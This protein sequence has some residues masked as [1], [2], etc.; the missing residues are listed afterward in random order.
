MHRSQPSP[1]A[2]RLTAW[3]VAATV[4]PLAGLAWLGRTIVEH[5]RDRG[6]IERREQAL[7]DSAAALKRTLAEAEERLEI[8][9]SADDISAAAAVFA[10]RSGAGLAVFGH[11]GLLGRGGAALPYYPAREDAGVGP[12][13]LF[14]AADREEV[15][16][17][18]AGAIAALQPLVQSNDSGVRAEALL[19]LARNY[20]KAGDTARTLAAY[21]ALGALENATAADRPA[22]LTAR[23]GRAI[24]LRDAARTADLRRE[25]TALIA[26]LDDGRW[27]L[28][29]AQYE[30]AREQAI[31]WTGGAGAAPIDADRLTLADA[32]EAAWHTWR[33]ATTAKAVERQRR[34]VRTRHG[35]A[36]VLTRTTA[37][38]LVMFVAGTRFLESAWLAE[39]RAASPDLDFALTEGDGTPVI[40]RADAPPQQQT[41]RTAYMTSLPWTVHAISTGSSPSRLSRT[42]QLSLGAVALTAIMLLA[43]AYVISRAIAR[44]VSVAALQSDFVAAV[45]HEFRTPLTTIRQLSELLTRGRVS[46]DD[47]RQQFYETLLRESDRLQRLVE[48]LLDFGRMEARAAEYRFDRVEP[49]PFVREVVTDFQQQI[50]AGFVVDLRVRGPLPPIRADRGSL[51]RVLWNLLD[52]AAKY[53]PE[54]RS[55]QIEVECADAHVL[56]HVRDRGIGIPPHE[57]ASIFGK[58]VRG[59][60]A[61]LASIKGTGLGLAM[62]SRIVEAHGGRITV[63]SAVGVGSTFTVLLP[64]MES[65]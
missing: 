29:R 45:S 17:N 20:R 37:D 22:G 41:V 28:T 65:A 11:R 39:L 35:S 40:G 58:F 14:A 23:Q 48:S 51:S 62:A 1:A 59:A 46:S 7:G 61:R 8:V 26:D 43:S 47:R 30:Y 42:A 55:V 4:L 15:A 3:F 38:R 34:P 54:H 16:D 32:A 18:P 12:S 31:D 27:T 19:R 6:I 24:V 52:N 56:V 9:A 64:I 10:T 36:L 33:S 13:M 2:R 25:A 57:Q 49:E 50:D 63:E 60:H 53:S 5:D 21:D 44:E